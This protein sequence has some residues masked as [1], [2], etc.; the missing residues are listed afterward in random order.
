MSIL[1]SSLTYLLEKGKRSRH[2][3]APDS[4]LSGEGVVFRLTAFGSY[5]NTVAA[6]ERIKRI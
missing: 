4:A 2:P 3:G 1:G 6:I 5:E